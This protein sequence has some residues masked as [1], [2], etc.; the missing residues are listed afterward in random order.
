MSR[1]PI[2]RI[3]D[4]SDHGGYM[5]TASGKAKNR[6]LNICVN[7]DLHVCPINGHGTTPVT[8][9]SGYTS[10]GGKKVVRVGDKAGCGATISSG[11][12]DTVSS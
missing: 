6:G 5:I 9:T 1:V 10:S 8:A 7:G 11:S 4:P 2:V 12:P 3:N